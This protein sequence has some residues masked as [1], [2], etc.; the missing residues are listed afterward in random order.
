MNEPV[1]LALFRIGPIHLAFPALLIEEVVRGPVEL[2]PFPAAARHVLGAFSL[3]GRPVP[4]LDLAAMIQPAAAN[5][6]LGPVAF[7]V[8]IRHATGRFALQ[9]DE[10]L[11]LVTPTADRLTAL[12][13]RGGPGLFS[14]LYTPD[15]GGRIAVV[16]DLEA[17]LQVDGV[18]SA[19]LAPPAVEATTTAVPGIGDDASTRAHVVVRV[20]AVRIGLDA[21]RVRSVEVRPSALSSTLRHPVMRGFHP[22]LG[23]MVPV[24][25]LGALLGISAAESSGT[26]AP[27]VVYERAGWRIALMVDEVL[28]LERVSGVAPGTPSDQ[29]AGHPKFVSGSF[30]AR[31]GALVLLLDESAVRRN[32]GVEEGVE[33]SRIAAGTAGDEGQVA[34]MAHV[35]PTRYVVHRVGGAWFAT[36]LAGLET[37][38]PLPDDFLEVRTSGE[39]AAGVCLRL[40]QSLAVVDLAVLLGAPPTVLR[41]GGRL[42]CV[43]TTAGRHGFVV[44]A[45]DSLHA[46]VPRLLPARDT[47]RHGVVPPFTH[48]IRVR[49]AGADRAVCVLDLA[50]LARQ[51]FGSCRAA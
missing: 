14:E 10:V 27:W 34:A 43:T 39:A 18:R 47:A 32:L 23:R 46:A 16:L 17:V 40:G 19:V 4:A 1:R 38:L 15:D 3:R 12:E 50:G 33:E 21:D 31:D 11:G 6:P 42:L 29:T 45:V 37:V 5:E 2:T 24:V 28:T 25:D 44:D 20:G 35:E 41:P 22:I 7:A 51:V 30:R 13:T 36:E 26:S 48:M 49:A 8:V 9:V